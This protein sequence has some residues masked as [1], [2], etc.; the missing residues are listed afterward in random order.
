VRVVSQTIY[1]T[2]DANSLYPRFNSNT[3]G[4]TTVNSSLYSPIT[5]LTIDQNQLKPTNITKMGE[6]AVVLIS[7]FGVPS[8]EEEVETYIFKIEA[9]QS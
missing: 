3:T 6:S 7:V 5:V 8:L 1:T 2:E 9:T 4:V